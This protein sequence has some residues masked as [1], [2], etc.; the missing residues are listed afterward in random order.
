MSLMNASYSEGVS[1]KIEE[2]WYDEAAVAMSEVIVPP[3]TMLIH[4]TE[5]MEMRC[6][7]CLNKIRSKN[8]VS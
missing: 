7:V 6:R 8:E 2:R 1:L 3:A 4:I 5:V